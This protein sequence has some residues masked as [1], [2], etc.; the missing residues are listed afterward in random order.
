[1]IT[2]FAET[3]KKA[4]LLLQPLLSLQSAVQKRIFGEKFWSVAP[5]FVCLLCHWSG[6]TAAR[7]KATKHRTAVLAG[8]GRTP[9]HVYQE[10][11]KYER[12]VAEPADHK[13][14]SAVRSC[15][16][17]RQ[18]L[19]PVLVLLML[20]LLTMDWPGGAS[21]GVG[22]EHSSAAVRER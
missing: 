2:A 20:V 17:S 10:G 19:A 18:S 11:G 13:R 16:I 15:R 8:Q 3:E 6:A 14:K 7:K 12:V 5:P 9:A 4:A 1:V 22:L 21:G